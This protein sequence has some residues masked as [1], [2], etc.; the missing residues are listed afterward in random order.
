MKKAKILS[1]L[2]SV[3]ILAQA[4]AL[5]G[6]AQ[7]TAPEP[8]RE[9]QASAI[10]AETA[11]TTTVETTLSETTAPETTAFENTTAYMPET[12]KSA[13][14]YNMG[15]EEIIYAYEPD[16][17]VAPG[18]LTK[19]V[20]AYIVLENCDL[21]E[22]VTNTTLQKYDLPAGAVNIGLYRNETLTVRD[23][24]AAMVLSGASDA[25]LVLA[26]YVAGSEEAMAKKMNN[27]VKDLGCTDTRFAD[28]TGMD[29]ENS[30]TTAR[31]MA[32]IL[33]AALKN[34][35]FRTLFQT[36]YYEI[37][38]T[39]RSEVRGLHTSNY[40][41]S[42][43]VIP[44]FYDEHVTGG[45]NRYMEDTGAHL[46]CTVEDEGSYIAILLGAE[47]VFSDNGWHVKHYGNFEEMT[48]LLEAC[49]P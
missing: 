28:V 23:L 37:P 26:D 40:M 43:S 17:Q 8:V 44:E 36:E 5:S 33:E 6:C 10:P 12:A 38:A 41:M 15:N 30:C 2:L 42:Q 34:E 27:W 47:R 48:A 49:L 45:M 1:V 46:I 31:E 19:M 13:L 21:D 39:D 7:K 3:S 35:A 25:A 14:L 29:T 20:A 32:R 18:G 4:A 9:T 24:T 11:E 16:A 22:K